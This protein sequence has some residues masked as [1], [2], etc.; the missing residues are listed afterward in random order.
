MS[1]LIRFIVK[2]FYRKINRFKMTNREL[3]ELSLSQLIDLRNRANEMVKLKMRVEGQ[4]NLDSLKVGMI[5]NYI[6]NT[7]KI[8]GE[9][10]EIKK[11]NKVNAQCKSLKT[12][13]IWNIKLAN[14]KPV[15]NVKA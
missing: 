13:Q 1:Y 14:I 4:M 9:T 3:N 2:C 12:G 15:D 8:T 6:G 10:F 5:V 7:N 11:I